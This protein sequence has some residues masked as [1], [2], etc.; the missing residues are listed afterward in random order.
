MVLS[1]IIYNSKNVNITQNFKIQ[2]T[3]QI[4]NYIYTIIKTMDI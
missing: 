2:Y 4:S 3:V 1:L